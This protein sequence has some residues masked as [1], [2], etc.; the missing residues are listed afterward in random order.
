MEEIKVANAS[1]YSV[2]EDHFEI[3]AK[4]VAKINK[5]G[6]THIDLNVTG[7]EY[8]LVGEAYEKFVTFTVTH[9]FSN[10]IQGYKILGRKF[11]DP[12]TNAVIVT[13]NV[14]KSHRNSEFK[15]DHCNTRRAKKNLL[16]I[17]KDDNVIQVGMACAKDYFGDSIFSTCFYYEFIDS[18]EEEINSGNFYEGSFAPRYCNVVDAVAL[19]YEVIKR[20]GRYISKN[21]AEYSGNVAKATSF[22]V[23]ELILKNASPEKE[24]I[25]YAKEAIAWYLTL[26]TDSAFSYNV[27]Q[28]LEAGFVKISMVGMVAFIPKSYNT[29]LV[30]AKAKAERET[31]NTFSDGYAGEIG[32]K[33]TAKVVVTRI[34]SYENDWGVTYINIMKDENG[35][36]LVWKTGKC[37]KE[38]AIYQI[39]GKIK[40]ISEYRDT[41]QTILTR[42]KYQIEE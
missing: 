35:L 3:I 20:D 42:C 11:R 6:K 16:V 26:P 21:D 15:C 22:K 9:D 40:D 5:R 24:S 13:E 27:H 36:Q 8:K 1:G 7:E 38:G 31:L 34:H 33:I 28:I 32:E 23:N 14:P 41:K 18:L 4:K 17:Q 25:D 39:T 10:L 30:N 2:R 29:H 19:A 37:L 12:I